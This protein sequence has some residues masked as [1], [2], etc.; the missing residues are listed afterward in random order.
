MGAC[1]WQGSQAQETYNKTISDK[2]MRGN[3]GLNTQH[4]IDGIGTRCKGRQDKT[5]GK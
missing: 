4:V 2:G 3:K 5:N 1:Q